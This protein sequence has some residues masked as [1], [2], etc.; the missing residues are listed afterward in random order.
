LSTSDLL[1]RNLDGN[2]DLRVSD[3]D[4][5]INQ[6]DVINYFDIINL[7]CLNEYAP[8][9]GGEEWHVQK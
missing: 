6:L 3:L 9:C 7:I 1:Q 5:V 4:K 8:L 2:F